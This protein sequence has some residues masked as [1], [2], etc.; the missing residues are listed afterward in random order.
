MLHW[1]PVFSNSGYFNLSILVG[2]SKMFPIA[3]LTIL[4]LEIMVRK[5]RF[6]LRNVVQRTN[7]IL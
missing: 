1:K 7:I 6:Q 5:P 2:N 3:L 4:Y